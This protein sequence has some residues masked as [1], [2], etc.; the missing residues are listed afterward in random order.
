MELDHVVVAAPDLATGV[1]R[2]REA[3]GLVAVAGGRHEGL[4]PETRIVPLRGA[5]LEILAVVDPAEAS[6]S[7]LGRLLAERIADVGW[8]P[9]AWAVRVDDVAAVAARLR[10]S[11][12]GVTRGGR[13]AALAGLREA[14]TT[15]R[16]PFFIERP[17]PPRDADAPPLAAP[18][19]ARDAQ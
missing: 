6:A 14:P 5:Y 12:D 16:L 2:L 9:I 15:P 19:V 17:E 7:A 11:G 18:Q 13:T 1:E 4:G 10:L 8:G 3:L